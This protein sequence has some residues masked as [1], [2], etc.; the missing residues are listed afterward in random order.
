MTN[1]ES[2]VLLFFMWAISF[3]LTVAIFV[4]IVRRAKIENR[5]YWML[6]CSILTI[7]WLGLYKGLAACLISIA[8]SSGY[9]ATRL[10]ARR[11]GKKIADSF[12]IGHNLFFTS[13]EQSMPMYLSMLAQL[14]RS[15][16]SIA[17]AKEITLP[18]LEAG[19]EILEG[20]F[21]KQPKI[22]AAR[23]A[24]QSHVASEELEP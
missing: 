11:I 16:M 19:F 3:V 5:I 10:D 14:E 9:I 23:D 7:L 21:G 12:G 24:I 4:F 18:Y 1:A 22:D 17:E 15:G 20:R 2:G 8:I 13:L 6:G